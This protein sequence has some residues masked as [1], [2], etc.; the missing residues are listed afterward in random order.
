[1]SPWPMAFGGVLVVCFAIYLIRRLIASGILGEGWSLLDGEPPGPLGQ[2]RG[3]DTLPS[4]GEPLR[5]G[6]DKGGRNDAPTTPRPPAPA[7]QTPV[8]PLHDI[9]LAAAQAGRV[10][11]RKTKS[12]CRPLSGHALDSHRCVCGRTI[13]GNAIWRHRRHCAKW[14]RANERRAARRK[15]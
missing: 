13:V 2:R 8:V 11:R 5:E 15:R 6:I 10:F 12:R 3:W 9:R 4:P 14:M 7:A 1:M